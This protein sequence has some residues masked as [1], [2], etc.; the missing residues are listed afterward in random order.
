MVQQT[1]APTARQT[2]T[3]AETATLYGIGRNTA[4]RLAQQDKMPVPR[5]KLGDRIV[6]RRTDVWKD[7]G[8]T[9]DPLAEVPDADQG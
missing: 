3:V 9:A 6:F 7:L 4:Y 1:A 5:I 8:L 2:Y